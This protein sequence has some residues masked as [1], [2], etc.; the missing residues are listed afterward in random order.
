[1]A[2]ILLAWELGGGLGHLSASRPLVTGLVGQGHRVFAALRDLSRAD[3]MFG[4]AD[5]SLLQAP[6]RSRRTDVRINPLRS[7][8][9]ILLCNGFADAGELRAMAGA[10]RSLYDYVQPDL[11]VFDH[12]P[13]ALLAARAC[14]A[15]RALIGTGF[16]AP[17]DTAPMPDLRLWLKDDSQRLQEAEQRTLDNANGVLQ[18]WNLPP[19]GR[20][21]QLFGDVDENFL[22]SMA[23]LDPK[24]YAGSRN[25]QAYWGSWPDAGGV[26]PQWPEGPGKRIF[27]YLKPF[28]A[29]PRLLALLTELGCPALLY[30]DGIDPRLP[31]RF[32]SPRLHFEQ[33]PVDLTQVATQCDLA[34]LNGTH[35]TTVSM[36]LAG[37]PLL[38][39]PLYLEQGLNSQA[40][41]RMGAG[42][43]AAPNRPEQIAVKLMQ[44]LG[45]DQ[46]AQAANRFAARYADL[47]PARQVERMLTRIEALLA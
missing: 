3:R 12:S 21:A 7:F 4:S 20:I 23:E 2:N 14:P 8:P 17:A 25:G 1:M 42:L 15:R 45:S 29:L 40:V 44:L 22:M 32:R 37:K 43:T 9:H 47:V 30:V 39:I 11:I 34:I 41:E 28:P 38:Q 24:A 46:Y 27:A 16:C 36:L 19:L 6:F 5:V 35:G 10:W 26:A 18:R 33:R 13:T 31:Q